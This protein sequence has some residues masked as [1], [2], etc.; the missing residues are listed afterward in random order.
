MPHNWLS[1]VVNGV[2]CLAGDETQ[3]LAAVDLG[4]NSFHMVIVKADSHGNFQILDVEK[5]DVRLGSGSAG[6]SVITSE[7]EDRAVAAIKRLKKIASLRGATM[8]VVATSAVREARNRR[9]FVRRILDAA[10]VEVEVVSGREEACLIY[11]GILQAMPVYNRT[12]LTVD[13]GGG[14]TEFVIGRKG[15]PLLATSLKLGHIRL[16]ER[17]AS[18]PVL[19]KGELDEMRRYIRVVLNDSGVVEAVRSLEGDIEM[20]IGSSGTIETIEQMIHLSTPSQNQ[21][22]SASS[23][24]LNRVGGAQGPN[25][26]GQGGA[27]ESSGLLGGRGVSAS[28]PQMRHEPNTCPVWG[29]KEREFTREQLS[30]MVKKIC[31]AKTGEARAKIAGLPE[32]RVDVIV[33]GAVLLE[34]IFLALGIQSMKVSPYALREGVIVDTLSRTCKDYSVSTDLRRTSVMNLARKFNTERRLDSALHSAELAKQ[35][36]GGL[37]TC[38]MGGEDCLSGAIQQLEVESDMEILEAATILHYVGMFISHKGYH[39]HSYYLIKHSELLLGYTPME[40]EMVALLV[41]YHRKKVP[42]MKDEDLAK[43]PEEVRQKIRVMAAVIRIAVALDRCDTG[44][45]ERVLVL[46]DNE[47]CVLVRDPSWPLPPALLLWSSTCLCCRPT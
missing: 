13:I 10:G 3:L 7:A 41:R 16:T 18:D 14:S 44:A 36:L 32:K 11:L 15:K 33:G 31:K 23:P 8:R 40:I 24:G 38:K 47:S 37:L 6:F 17:F 21:S 34:E 25:G 27:G 26:K 19:H 35:I 5:E 4:T 29:F 28:T 42:S 43:L 9:A 1:R 46:Q 30:A 22:S 2:W 45:V 12:V 39:K 20:A